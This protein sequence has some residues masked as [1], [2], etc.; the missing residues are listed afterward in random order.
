[1]STRRR[2]DL[3][4]RRQNLAKTFSK[5]PEIAELEKQLLPAVQQGSEEMGLKLLLDE[6]I[7]DFMRGTAGKGMESI[8]DEDKA[9]PRL[10]LTQRQSPHL[11]EYGTKVG[12]WYLPNAKEGLGPRLSFVPVYCDVYG[13]LQDPSDRRQVLA[14]TKWLL[15]PDGEKVRMVWDPSETPFTVTLPGT[16]PAKQEVW[17]TDKSVAR[18]RLLSWGS[19]EKGNPKGMAATRF[20]RVFGYL[21]DHPK[22]SPVEIS[23]GRSSYNAGKELMGQLAQ[24]GTAVYGNKYILGSREVVEP[25]R[26]YLVYTI[27]SDGRLKDEKLFR[28]LENLESMLQKMRLDVIVDEDE[29]GDPEVVPNG[30]GAIPDLDV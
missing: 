20:I 27:E 28:K 2:D 8:P 5:D 21:L 7:P 13:L 30:N 14:R 16:S 4:T 1:M 10:K 23:F 25:G 17:N 19:Y 11:G 3:K 22:L 9:R 12:D 24:S 15:G 29:L 26:N 18:S 6:E